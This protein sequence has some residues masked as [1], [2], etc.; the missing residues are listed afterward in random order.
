MMAPVLAGFFA[1]VLIVV[2]FAYTP[3]PQ[4]SR[5]IMPASA[6]EQDLVHKSNEL[7][8]VQA[9]LKK[10]QFAQVG[11][12]NS[13]DFVV[14]DDKGSITDTIPALTISYVGSPHTVFSLEEYKENLHLIRYENP[15]LWIVMALDGRVLDARLRCAISYGEGTGFVD[16]IQG[17][18]RAIQYLDRGFCS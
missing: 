5:L 18:D 14:Y 9:F 10:Y 2:L 4:A 17:S 12:Q 11:L 16:V 3:N 7:D 15:S 8:A 13:D 1:G 6:E